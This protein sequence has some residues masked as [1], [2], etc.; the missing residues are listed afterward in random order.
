[1]LLLG[2]G[3]SSMAS[4]CGC[5]EEVTSKFSKKGV[6]WSVFQEFVQKY[7]GK[8]FECRVDASDASKGSIRKC[9]KDMTTTDV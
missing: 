6:K 8:V 7:Q 9:F 4:C 3:L 5:N 1:M 2:S